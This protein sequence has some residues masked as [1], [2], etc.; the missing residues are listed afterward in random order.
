MPGLGEEKD[1]LLAQACC[2]ANLMAFCVGGLAGLRNELGLSWVING[3]TLSLLS[4]LSFFGS[5]SDG[6]GSGGG[7]GDGHHRHLLPVFLCY[8]LMS[9][10]LENPSFPDACCLEKPPPPRK[11]FLCHSVSSEKRKHMAGPLTRLPRC[12]SSALMRAASELLSSVTEAGTHLQRVNKSDT[13]CAAYS[14]TSLPNLSVHR[15]T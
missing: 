2:N 9:C 14:R 1:V 3:L 7:G 8:Q 6:G 15:Y 10:R 12:A 4:F 13:A 5:C 11:T